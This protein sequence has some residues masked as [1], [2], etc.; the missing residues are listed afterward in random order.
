MKHFIKSLFFFL[1]FAAIAYVFLLFVWGKLMPQALKPNLTYKIGSYGNLFSRIKDIENYK[2]IDVLFIGTSHAYRGFDTRNFDSENYKTFNLGSSSQTPIQSKILLERY[3]E[4]L[5]PKTI[6]FEVNP[7]TFTSDGVEASLDIVANDKNDL[8]SLK[9]AFEIN[10]IKTWNT[11]IFAKINDVFDLNKNFVEPKQKN[12]DTYIQGGFVE[13]QVTFF[14]NTTF[15]DTKWVFNKKQIKAFEE[16][17]AL[18]KSKNIKLILL[19][20]PITKSLYKS[21]TNQ[22]EFDS[23]MQTF[24]TY[25]DFNKNSELNDSL[26]FYDGE[27][28]NQS[29]V[30]IFNEKMKILKF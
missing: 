30:N 12:E 6:V 7:E 3:L 10:N 8:K 22:I 5:N 21:F 20:T 13:K 29:G 14:K 16:C 28:L 11:L 18:I 24:G 26:H 19:D 1:F 23:L 17:V 25:Y 27:H 9:M 2:D 15:S 4:R